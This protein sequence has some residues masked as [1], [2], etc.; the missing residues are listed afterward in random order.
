MDLKPQSLFELILANASLTIFREEGGKLSV[1]AI[2]AMDP[3][4]FDQQW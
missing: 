4:Q 1:K 3:T 2:N